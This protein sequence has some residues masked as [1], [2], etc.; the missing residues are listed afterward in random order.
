MVSHRQ[1]RVADLIRRELADLLQRE[2]QDPRFEQVTITGVEVSPDL[3]NAR[4]YF[5]VFRPD[6]ASSPVEGE[7]PDSAVEVQEVVRAFDKASGYFRTALASRIE[8]RHVPKLLFRF[9]NSL[10]E[11]DR[12]ERLLREIAEEEEVKRET[13]G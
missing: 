7:Q 10:N 6:E 13:G 9:D 3:Q 4:V 5:S 12:I 8:L 2:A 1:R 11:G